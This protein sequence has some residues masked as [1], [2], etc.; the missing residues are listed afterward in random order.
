YNVY[1][2][3]RGGAIDQVFWSHYTDVAK[4]PLYPFG[5]GLS[6]TKFAYSNLKVSKA[7]YKKGETVSVS[8][9]VKNTGSV[10][11][12]EVVQLYIRDLVASLARPIKE[13]KAFELAEIK[14]GETKKITFTLTDKELG[15]FDNDGNFLVEPGAFKVFVGTSS[16]DVFESGF[17]LE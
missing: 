17:E 15:F 3:G 2:T 11:G 5:F 7:S 14:K 1:N 10:D 12:K 16:D 6:Y 4:T 9:Q 13:L 8:I